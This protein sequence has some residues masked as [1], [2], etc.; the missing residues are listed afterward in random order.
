MCY[1]NSPK[2]NFS[3]DLERVKTISGKINKKL[4]EVKPS[5]DE[6]IDK[7]TI[8]E[9]QDLN[10]IVAIA[11]FL[12]VKY[13]DK[14]E[15]RSTLKEFVSIISDT[16]KSLDDIDDEIAELIMSAEDSI[17]KVKDIHSHISDKSD[18]KKKYHDG[19]E[20]SEHETS[21]INLTN[22]AT[23]VNTVEYQQNSQGNTA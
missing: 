5:E 2:R 7:L 19:P 23:E 18:F 9:L 21:A 11:D 4:A 12:L 17:G 15:I 1:L 13:S 16:A 3:K 14:K 8:E 22:F 10:K 6:K 20:Y